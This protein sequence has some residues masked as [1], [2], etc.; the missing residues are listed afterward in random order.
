VDLYQL[1]IVAGK[2]ILDLDTAQGFIVNER[3]AKMVGYQNPA[4]I[5]GK[6]MS[7]GRR[8]FSLPVV[9][10]VQDFHTMSLH[11][12]IEPTVLYNRA[13][14]YSTLS[15]KVN[16]K[17]FQENIKQI[18]TKWEN[19]YPDHIFSYKFLDEEVREF[20][21]G[22]KLYG[23]SKNKRSGCTQSV[24]C[25]GARHCVVVLQRVCKV[26]HR[27][28]FDCGTVGLVCNEPVA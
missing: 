7:Q 17:Q 15:L 2:N 18:Q 28:L 4:D 1:K 16:L 25:F 19:T 6:Q 12:P 22:E 11:E 10:V 24:G 26:D 23:Q 3:L 21:E 5:V 9:G 27:G 8:K 14:N 20:Y 13:R